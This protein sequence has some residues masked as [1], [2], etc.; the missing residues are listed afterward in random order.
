[1]FL[2]VKMMMEIKIMIILVKKDTFEL[3]KK[4][5]RKSFFSLKKEDDVGKR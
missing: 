2:T 5:I 3:C 4:L 1:M